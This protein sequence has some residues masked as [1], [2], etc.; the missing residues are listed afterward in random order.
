MRGSRTS[1]SRSP[2]SDRGLALRGLEQDRV[3][4]AI[5]AGPGRDP[6]ES[7]LGLN[8][9][10]AGDD[11]ARH[12]VRIRRVRFHRDNLDLLRCGGPAVQDIGDLRAQ[13]ADLPVRSLRAVELQALGPDEG[14]LLLPTDLPPSLLAERP[15]AASGR[16]PFRASLPKGHRIAPK[17][18]PY[19][20]VVGH[21]MWIVPY[22]RRLVA[23]K[24]RRAPPFKRGKPACGFPLR[25]YRIKTKKPARLPMTVPNATV[26]NGATGPNERPRSGGSFRN[27]KADTLRIPGMMRSPNPINTASRSSP[28]AISPFQLLCSRNEEPAFF[29]IP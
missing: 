2:P 9:R 12:E 21:T 26:M 8:R 28:A 23:R 3:D 14:V 15:V 19:M 7:D 18:G 13:D 16:L 22:T 24:P 29:G 25:T 6:R 17:N 11:V 4:H 5:L 20:T 10:A 27:V 1:G